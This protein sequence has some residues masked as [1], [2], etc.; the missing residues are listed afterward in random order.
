MKTLQK[1]EMLKRDQVIIIFPIPMSDPV[2]DTT[3]LSSPTSAQSAT[4]WPNRRRRGSSN[5]ITHSKT[6]STCI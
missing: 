3:T 1:A 5:C 2:T 6:R 4:F